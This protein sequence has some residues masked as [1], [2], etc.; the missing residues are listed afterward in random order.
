[1][2]EERYLFV[3]A[4]S[5]VGPSLKNHL[6]PYCERRHLEA[7][8]DDVA[9][10]EAHLAA[11]ASKVLAEQD[12]LSA[13]IQGGDTVASG[14]LGSP[15]DTPAMKERRR[16]A[17]TVSGLHDPAARLSDMDAEGVAAD[18][19]FAGGQNGELLPFDTSNDHKL[20]RLGYEIFNRWLRE[21]TSEAP[22]RLIGVAQI[23]MDDIPGAV[24]QVTAAAEAGFRTVNFPAPRRGLLPYTEPAYEP[25]WAACEDLQL[26][27][28]THGGGGDR[29]YWTGPGARFAARAEGHFY[30]RRALWG[31]IFGGVFERH[32][33]LHFVLT[34]QMGAW[35]PTTLAHLDAI[36]EDNLRMTTDYVKTLPLRPSEYWARQVYLANSF[37]SRAE[38]LERE[39]I[40]VGQI[41]YGSDYPHAESIHPL[42]R[43][44][45]RHTFSGIDRKEVAMMLGD[46]AVECFRLDEAPL[47]AIADRVGPTVEEVSRPPKEDELADVPPFCLGFRAS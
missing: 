5:H 14:R 10:T 47:R 27:L 36:Y 39:E 33:T 1:M 29:G 32:P 22:E 42:T 11:A 25:F 18:V 3:S 43:L 37:M 9:R 2:T 34:E 16:F 15:N 31:L 24:E 45:L 26:T 21:Y 44:A 28:N 40:G 4:D 41:M 23:T 20:H 19:I 12:P 6:R 35:V 30:G 17:E 46:N 38:A 8:D 13:T 7:F